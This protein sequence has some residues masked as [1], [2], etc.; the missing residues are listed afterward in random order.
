MSL[1]KLP[2]KAAQQQFLRNSVTKENE[3]LI[4][5]VKNDD[6]VQFF[7]ILSR[8]MGHSNTSP[9]LNNSI[10]T[11]DTYGA[12][13]LHLCSLH[14]KTTCVEKLL[15][16]DGIELNGRDCMGRTP[17]FFAAR[18]GHSEILDL[19]LAEGADRELAA[20]NGETPLMKAASCGHLEC[21]QVLL[22]ESIG[23]EDSALS[24]T[25]LRYLNQKDL[26]GNTALHHAAQKGQKE[27]IEL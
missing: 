21:L 9:S 26:S 25:M 4:N 18:N 15:Q 20:E 12:T 17:C 10:N 3:E 14:G 1:D 8:W 24:P 13:A 19:L 7:A 23:S 22:R 27:A 16:I 5:A 6:I 2:K 11:K